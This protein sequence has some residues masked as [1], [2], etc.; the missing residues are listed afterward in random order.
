MI[1]RLGHATL[2]F[3][4]EFGRTTQLFLDTVTSIFAGK[5][6]PRL[7]LEQMV[8]IGIDSLPI[9]LTSA[10]FVGMVFAV[11]IATEFV[12]FGASKYVGGIMGIAVAR[13][14]APALTGVVIA[15]RVAAAIAAEI[16]TMQVTEQ[17][18]ALNALGTNP[19]RYLVIPRFIA[20]TFMLP[21]LTVFANIF[22]FFGGYFVSIYLVKINAVDY[23]NSAQQLMKYS[24]VYGGV[25]KSLIFG[26]II[27]VIACSKGL[28]TMGGAMGVGEATTSSVVASL[29]ALFVVNY[30][31][32]VLL[33]K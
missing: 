21:I 15:S 33:F 10:T 4:E 6:N 2:E 19:V 9:A 12:K 31:L 29:M 25:F 22:C 3:F 30:F 26:M 14:L 8:K 17:I 28:H 13:E 27:S 24:D 18:D 32:S 23:M 1:E 5:T 7:V 16:G 11:Q 20:C